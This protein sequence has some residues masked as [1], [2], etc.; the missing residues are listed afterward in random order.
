LSRYDVFGHTIEQSRS[1]QI[2]LEFAQQKNQSI[3]YQRILAPLDGFADAVT[4]FFSQGGQGAN[5]TLPFKEQA[6]ALCDSLTERAQQA[7]ACNTLWKKDGALIGDNTDGAGLVTDIRHNHGWQLQNKR[8]LI[9]GAGGAVRGVLGPLLA[10]SPSE[11]TIAN[12]TVE[13]AEQLAD[14]FHGQGIPVYGSGLN[15]IRGT[16]DVIINAISAGLSGDMPPLPSTLLAA[17]C[18]CYDMIYSQDG[19]TPFLNWAELNRAAATSDGLGM[20]IEQ[21]AEAFL[22]WHGWRPDG[23]AIAAAM[24]SQR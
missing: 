15:H 19:S 20:L 24:R 14:I 1:T 17:D 7:G 21:A 16:F 22:I 2:H 13:K 11:I 10:Q 4:Q 9:L 5:V 18:A 6:F 3:D 8:I 12:R 23:V